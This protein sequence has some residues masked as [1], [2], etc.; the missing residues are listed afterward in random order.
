MQIMSST[1]LAVLYDARSTHVK[2]F[3]DV[4]RAH[5]ACALAPVESPLFVRTV[6]AGSVVVL[7]LDPP[8]SE[9]LSECDVLHSLPSEARGLPFR[10]LFRK[11]DNVP[12][13]RAA[14]AG[15]R[16]YSL[17][18]DCSE[19]SLCHTMRVRGIS[20]SLHLPG[21]ECGCGHRGLFGRGSL[22]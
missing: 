3:L 19:A 21:T 13:Y 12:A 1:I 11:R 20:L 9:F 6:A 22:G 18:G 14:G 10:L 5:V 8:Q 17:S 2:V 16:W 15:H 4:L 7:T